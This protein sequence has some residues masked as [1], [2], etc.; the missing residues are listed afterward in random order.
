MP[1]LRGTPGQVTSN[2]QQQGSTRYMHF[3]ACLLCVLGVYFHMHCP[4]MHCL[5]VQDMI[6]RCSSLCV[7]T[8]CLRITHARTFSNLQQRYSWSLCIPLHICVQSKLPWCSGCNGCNPKRAVLHGQ[9]NAA[10]LA[11]HGMQLPHC[12]PAGMT[13]S[14]QPRSASCSCPAPE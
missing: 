12:T 3:T 2:A 10:T 14:W 4:P 9:G 7:R 1:G 11:L 8:S 13:T 5:A 6:D